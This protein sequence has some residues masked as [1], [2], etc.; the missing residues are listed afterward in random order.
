MRDQQ[1]LVNIAKHE[2][3][4]LAQWDMEQRTQT[5][6]ANRVHFVTIW[7]FLTILFL[8]IENTKT[9]LTVKYIYLGLF[10]SSFLKQFLKTEDIKMMLSK[11]RSYSK[12]RVCLVSILKNSF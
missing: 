9:R 11:N 2:T 3:N 4:D 1:Q 10:G 6:P 8:R 12:F 7:F 5:H